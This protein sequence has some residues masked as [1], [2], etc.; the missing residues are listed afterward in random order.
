MTSI[1]IQIARSELNT[2]R[3]Y[4][5]VRSVLLEMF[6]TANTIWT[7]K[8][9]ILATLHIHCTKLWMERSIPD[10]DLLSEAVRWRA[11]VTLTA[12]SQHRRFSLIYSDPNKNNVH[13][14]TLQQ[15]SLCQPWPIC[16]SKDLFW[17]II[18]YTTRQDLMFTNK[19]CLKFHPA[20]TIYKRVLPIQDSSSDN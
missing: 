10:W 16:F 5:T 15:L 14:T 11:G 12:G 7:Q 18:M 19:Y 8:K 17:R 1:P 3:F 2:A 4:T 9:K 6:W 13:S 20:S